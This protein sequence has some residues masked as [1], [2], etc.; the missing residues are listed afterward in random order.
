MA[1][2]AFHVR[3]APMFSEALQ[4]AAEAGNSLFFV[5]V[6][7][8]WLLRP[9]LRYGACDL[10]ALADRWL[11][12]ERSAPS[13]RFGHYMPHATAAF[14]DDLCLFLVPQLE[15]LSASGRCRAGTLGFVDEGDGFA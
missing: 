14:A 1:R 4:L 2:A 5:T 11:N 7:P 8:P 6:S 9:M 15:L 10:T 12:G 13:H 3:D